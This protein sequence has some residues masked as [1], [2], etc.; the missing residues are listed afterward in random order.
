VALPAFAAAAPR[1]LS[2]GRAAT[3]HIR[4]AHSSGVRGRVTGQTDRRT[5]HR[6]IDLAL[7]TMQAMLITS[8]LCT[9]SEQ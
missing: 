8:I 6:Y 9:A 5:L 2:A 3:D 7:H 4:R 1:L